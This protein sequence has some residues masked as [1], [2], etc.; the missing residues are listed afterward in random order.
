M[1]RHTAG[2]EHQPTDDQHAADRNESAGH[3]AQPAGH[4]DVPAASGNG[5]QQ[6]DTGQQQDAHQRTEQVRLHRGFGTRGGPGHPDQRIQR[7][8]RQQKTRHEH[9]QV[10]GTR[11]HDGAECAQKEQCVRLTLPG[12]PG[13]LLGAQGNHQQRCADHDG[14]GDAGGHVDRERSVEHGAVG[15]GQPDTGR[16]A[17][18]HQGGDGDDAGDPLP[19]ARQ[20]G[21]GEQRG[22]RPQQQ[23]DLRQQ[24]CQLRGH[25][26][27]FG[28]LSADQIDDDPGRRFDDVQQ[29]PRQHPDDQRQQQK[30]RHGKGFRGS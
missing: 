30:G 21:P 5:A 13:K 7:N 4:V 25:R 27:R 16:D 23:Q 11:D 24:G 1:A 10:I 9:Q 19:L 18:R 3:P 28:H 20:E 29:E 15:A 14:P 26:F 12:L 2:L 6:G 8:T 17:R 22:D